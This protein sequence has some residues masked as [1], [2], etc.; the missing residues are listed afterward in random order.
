MAEVFPEPC[1]PSGRDDEFVESVNEGLQC[2]ICRLPMKD[3]MITSNG[4]H[5]C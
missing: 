2:E 4:H 5:F 1:L 3:P